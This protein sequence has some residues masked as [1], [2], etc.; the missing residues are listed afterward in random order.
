MNA[1]WLLKGLIQRQVYQPQ[2]GWM[3]LLMKLV[4]A[5]GIMAAVLVLG[6]WWLPSWAEMTLFN[7][8]IG[9][10]VLCFGGVGVYVLS[11]M[12]FGFRLRHLRLSH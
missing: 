6:V 1:G 5:N 11:L 7:R 8:I 2:A 4:F 10:A 3:S 9:L 12:A